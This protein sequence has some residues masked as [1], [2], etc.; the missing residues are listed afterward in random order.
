[1]MRKTRRSTKVPKTPASTGSEGEA[2]SVKQVVEATVHVPAPS[3][4]V[5]QG[6]A[7]VGAL[8]DVLV[9]VDPPVGLQADQDAV[10]EELAGADSK[11]ENDNM[12]NTAPRGM[13]TEEEEIFPV[14]PAERSPARERMETPP[15][16]TPEESGP[17]T[18]IDDCDEGPQPRRKVRNRDECRRVVELELVRDGVR[19]GAPRVANPY[20]VHEGIRTVPVSPHD[21][22]GNEI[23]AAG[24][25]RPKT[26]RIDAEGRIL[27]P[28]YYGTHGPLPRF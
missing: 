27:D 9:P 21:R 18:E 15:P 10:S 1:M 19:V 13:E 22:I 17:E 11:V 12:N 2:D 26:V 16:C 5:Q 28:R 25:G 4:D 24:P 14:L 23:S 3:P 8:D 7:G 20:P 6:A